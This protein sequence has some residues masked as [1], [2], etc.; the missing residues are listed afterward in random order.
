MG[1][2]YVRAFTV[3][4]KIPP[5]KVLMHNHATDSAPGPM[6]S[7]RRASCSAPVAMRGSSIMPGKTMQKRGARTARA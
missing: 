5:G 6:T 2:R 1:M 7:R 3:P 4:K